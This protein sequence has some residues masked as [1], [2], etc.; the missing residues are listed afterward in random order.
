[1]KKGVIIGVLVILF[2]IGAGAYYYF[3]GSD[4][5]LQLV[6]KNAVF[7]GNIDFKSVLT[8]ADMDKV[9]E[10]QWFKDLQG[11]MKEEASDSPKDK[12]AME[13]FEHPFSSGVNIMSDVYFFGAMYG[14]A[15]V[16]AMVFDIKD[17]DQFKESILKVKPEAKIVNEKDY[18]AVYDGSEMA[19]AWNGTGAV[20]ATVYDY[21]LRDSLKGFLSSTFA[22]KKEESVLA[23]TFFQEYARSKKDMS[24]FMNFNEFDKLTSA[25]TRDNPFGGMMYGSM[26]GYLKGNYVWSNLEFQDNKILFT[27]V[28]KTDSDDKDAAKPGD[29]LDPKGLSEEH[30]NSLTQKDIYALFAI[31]LNSEKVFA[32]YDKIP[33]IS[34]GKA[35]IAAA[36]DM[37]VKSLEKIFGGEFSFALVGFDKPAVDSSALAMAEAIKA[38]DDS[39]YYGSDNYEDYPAYHNPMDD[40]PVPVFTFNF[41][42]NN[43]EGVQKLLAKY[44]ITKT[45]DGYYTYP[46]E[47]NMNTYLIENKFG[48]TVTNSVEVAKKMA[49][50]GKLGPPPA[51]VA[52]L[53]KGKS[54]AVFFDMVLDHYPLE[55]RNSMSKEMGERNYNAFA[56]YMQLFKDVTGSGNA[57]NSEVSINLNEG[58]GNSL[59]RLLAQADV[60]YKMVK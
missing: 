26:S 46:L 53:V 49:T 59:Y 31:A 13:V 23:N 16:G 15:F 35:Q 41:S 33:M 17:E 32:Y 6:P 12:K 29:W 21:E 55:I 44:G 38:E 60:A 20:V 39:E 25:L 42:S 57:S 4:K 48:Y 8:K 45:A 7:V 34:M 50:D 24:V 36:M 10:M 14:E 30:I 2:G 43:K 52:D 40:Y 47:R 11:K 37:D 56:T 27:T 19:L 1:M 18:K 3:K 28:R 54:S 9:K 51:R 5:H 58:K 22:R